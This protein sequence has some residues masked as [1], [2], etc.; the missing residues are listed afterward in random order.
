MTPPLSVCRTLHCTNSTHRSR[1]PSF[2]VVSV[3]CARHCSPNSSSTHICVVC[4]F[5]MEAQHVRPTVWFVRK[6][7]GTCT[8]THSIPRVKFCCRIWWALPVAPPHVSIY[9]F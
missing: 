9:V 2:V 8:P 3:H 5:F 4:W 7:F 1:I 6:F